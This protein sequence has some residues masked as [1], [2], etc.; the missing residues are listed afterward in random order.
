MSLNDR[1]Q[2]YVRDRGSVGQVI[3]EGLRQYMLGVYNYMTIGLLITAFVSYF[4]MATGAISLFYTQNANGNYGLSILGI[5]A[6]IAPF[7]GVFYFSHA[8]RTAPI[9]KVQI[10]FFVFSSLMG[11]SIA[12][13]LMMY[14]GVSVFRVFLITSGM[15]AGMS[16]YGYTTKKDLTAMGSFL[17]MGLWGIILASVVNIFLKSP[18]MYFVVSILGVVIFTGLTAFD[19]QKIKRIYYDGD[20]S[21]AT[22][23]KAISGA[24]ML[25][26]DFINLFLYMLRFFGNRRQ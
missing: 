23:R 8:L 13:I 1:Y 5:I 25:Y 9:A 3:D 17:Y 2:D 11:I 6:M 19:T 21:D 26:M 16:L 10:A 12:P 14:T 20:S 7:A 22:A 18:A 24:L 4:M 15:F